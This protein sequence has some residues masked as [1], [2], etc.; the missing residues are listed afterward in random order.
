M[1]WF[2]VRFRSFLGLGVDLCVGISVL[3]CRGDNIKGKGRLWQRS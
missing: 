3:H 1:S 2:Q